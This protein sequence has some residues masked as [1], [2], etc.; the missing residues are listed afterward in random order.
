MPFSFNFL[1]LGKFFCLLLYI[2]FEVSCKTS[3][4]VAL[5]AMLF[6]LL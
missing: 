3:L 6:M 4:P 5:K 1:L 2:E